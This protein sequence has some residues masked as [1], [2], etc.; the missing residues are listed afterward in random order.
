MVLDDF[1]LEVTGR[2][3][4][5]LDALR[6]IV[7]AGTRINV[8]SLAGE[9]PGGRRA[10]ARAVAGAGFV[11]VP[12]VTARRLTGQRE[13]EE[14]LEGLRADGTATEI[15]AVG[16]DPGT[17]LG[18]YADSL[19]LIESGLLEKHGVARV[20]IAGHP[21]GHPG[22]PGEVLWSSLAAR[23]TALR[24]RGLTGDVITQLGFDVAPV[25]DWIAALRERG[26][27]LPVR[28]GV[29]GPTEES[30]L[31]RLATRLG[32][33]TSP[34]AENVGSS[35]AAEAGRTS[36]ATEAGRTSP[37]TEAGR[38]SPAAPA[39]PAA[40]LRTLAGEYH[41]ERHGEVKLH[42]YT[43]GGL[44]STAEWITNFAKE[45]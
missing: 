33:A 3:A 44:K 17:P 35:P 28:V 40:F 14:L 42:F 9:D 24:A 32:I 36:P 15:F 11:P 6:G 4:G 26:V 31:R 5:E 43:F 12:H 41:P 2:D 13:F 39:T 16:G 45:G 19:A 7:P 29:P 38:A 34:A 1:S 25:L 21:A 37:A 22:I 30:R 18:P 10:T 8:T 27:D 20:S 23:V